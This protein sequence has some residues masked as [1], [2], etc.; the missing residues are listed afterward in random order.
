MTPSSFD[1]VSEILSRQFKI[2]AKKIQPLTKLKDLGLDS[3]A[4]IDFVFHLEDQLD[5]RIPEERLDPQNAGLTLADVCAALDDG[6]AQKVN[7]GA[8]NPSATATGRAATA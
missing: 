5:L 4:L 3:L 1:I 2:D 8:S 7:A 6:L